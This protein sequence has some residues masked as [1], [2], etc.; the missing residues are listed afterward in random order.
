[1]FFFQFF[2]Y[3]LFMFFFQFFIYYF[4]FIC[5]VSVLLYDTILYVFISLYKCQ[6]QPP[7]ARG[8]VYFSLT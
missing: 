4:I 1:M 6:I 5:P 3:Y 7:K 8:A 2:I